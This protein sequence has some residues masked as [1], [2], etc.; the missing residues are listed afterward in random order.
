ML[1]NHILNKFDEILIFVSSLSFDPLHPLTDENKQTLLTAFVHKSY[2]ADFVPTLSHNERLEFLWDSILGACIGSLLYNNYPEWSEAQ[3]T[4][5]KIALVREETLAKVARQINLWEQIFL[6]KGEEKQGGVDK[7]S[8]LSDSLEALI[9]AWYLIYGFEQV[10]HFIYNTVWKEL[11]E[12]IQTDCKSYKSL[13]Q[14]RAQGNGLPLPSYHTT[15]INNNGE[16]WFHS[17]LIINDT[18]YGVGEWKNKKK[19]QEE[20]AKDAYN[21]IISK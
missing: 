4:L 15:E 17:D 20:S 11:D 8:I 5:Y 13:I 9:G 18:S 7:D 21:K 2:A 14:E 6:S 3:M 12:L 1:N 19:S 16:I 10:Y